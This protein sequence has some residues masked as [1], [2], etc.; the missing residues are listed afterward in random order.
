[1]KSCRE[2]TSEVVRYSWTPFKGLKADDNE[3]RA[4][5]ELAVLDIVNM[6]DGEYIAR[7][8][9]RTQLRHDFEEK[10]E[11]PFNLEQDF[12]IQMAYRAGIRIHSPCLQSILKSLVLYYPGFDVQKNEIWLEEPF[13]QLFHYWD[14]LQAIIS[15]DQEQKT[16]ATIRNPDTGTDIA[17]LCTP[18]TYEHLNILLGVPLVEKVYRTLI[19]P[20][21]KLHSERKATYNM[22]W[23]L[24]KPGGIVFTQIRDKLAGFVVMK[25]LHTSNNVQT[26]P[27]SIL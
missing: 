14:D 8:P 17:I 3:I 11:E 24:F 15:G 13:W 2:D 19:L 10:A 20:E 7:S 16:Q 6:V 22:L 25:I 27:K 23:L 26:Y 12:Q 1:M 18:E 9:P 21:R 5:R 4:R